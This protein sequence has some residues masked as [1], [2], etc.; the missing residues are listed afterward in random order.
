MY[1]VALRRLDPGKRMA[2]FY[3]VSVQPTLFDQ[4]AVVRRWGRINTDGSRAEEWFTQPSEALIAADRIVQ[5]KRRRGYAFVAP[6][7]SMPPR[8]TPGAVAAPPMLNTGA[9]F[10]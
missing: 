8:L 6:A 5:V 7:P 3:A 1:A 2:R 10:S 9:L 4:W